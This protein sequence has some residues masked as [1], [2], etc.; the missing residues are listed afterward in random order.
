MKIYL[1]TNVYSN[2]KIWKILKIG[3]YDHTLIKKHID[4][5]TS[6]NIYLWHVD[7]DN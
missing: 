6:N 3:L 4:E 2:N 7:S 5:I 1:R